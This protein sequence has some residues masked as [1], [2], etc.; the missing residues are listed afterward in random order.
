MSA[1]LL[2]QSPTVV[3]WD[4]HSKSSKDGENAIHMFKLECQNMLLVE[5]LSLR[6]RL[7]SKDKVSLEIEEREKNENED[8]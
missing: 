5:I 8:N 6:S 3:D 7:E 4:T 1:I 2:L